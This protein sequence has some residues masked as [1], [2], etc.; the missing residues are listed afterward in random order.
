[1]SLSAGAGVLFDMLMSTQ[2][3]KHTARIKRTIPT[4]QTVD[5][6]QPAE[7]PYIAWDDRLA[8]FVMCDFIPLI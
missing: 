7:K 3:R 4:R 6:L 5:A 8:G 1:M 2:T